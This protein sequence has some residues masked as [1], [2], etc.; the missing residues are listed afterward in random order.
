MVC[1][2]IGQEEFRGKVDGVQEDA[3]EA[4]LPMALPPCLPSPSPRTGQ[5]AL[6]VDRKPH[7]LAGKA[8]GIGGCA[9]IGTCILGRRPGDDQGAILAHVV[10]GIPGGQGLGFLQQG[11]RGHQQHTVPRPNLP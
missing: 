9:D 5:P 3:G 2:P 11:H 8:H 6:T 1:V 10:A 7:L 4:R